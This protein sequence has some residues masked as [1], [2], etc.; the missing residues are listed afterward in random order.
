MFARVC[1][2]EM[3]ATIRRMSTSATSRCQFL[4]I[5]RERVARTPKLRPLSVALW[6]VVG[7]G[8]QAAHELR[9]ARASR[10]WTSVP[11]T[12]PCPCPLPAAGSQRPSPRP[13]HLSS[14]ICVAFAVQIGPASAV[15]FLLVPGGPDARPQGVSPGGP[16]P[17]RCP[18]PQPGDVRLPWKRPRCWRRRRLIWLEAQPATYSAPAGL[19]CA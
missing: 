10:S 18:V 6:G 2:C 8:R 16:G 4:F 12:E 17:A 9:R 11:L 13:R 7:R 15:S 14:K 1:R 19:V 5:H 3:I